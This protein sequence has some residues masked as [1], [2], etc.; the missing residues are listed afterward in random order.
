MPEAIRDFCRRTGQTVP[1]DEGAVIRCALES[2]ALR[3]RLVL[4]WLEQLVGGRIETIHIVGGGSQ[5]RQLCQ[6]T[7]DACQRAVL[8]GPVEATAIG[9]VLVQAIAAGDIGSIGEAREVGSPQF[10]AR[11]LRAAQR[12]R[13]WDA[14]FEKF[15][16]VG[17]AMNRI[18]LIATVVVL[19]QPGRH[20]RARPG[21]RAAGRRSGAVAIGIRVRR[22]HRWRRW[23]PWSCIGLAGARPARL[24]L[25]V[26]MLA[27]PA[28]RRVLPLHRGQPRPR[29]PSARGRRPGLFVATAILLLPVEAIGAAFGFWSWVNCGSPDE[30]RRI[31]R[32][33]LDEFDQ[34]FCNISRRDLAMIR[35]RHRRHRLHGHDPLPGLPEAQGGEGRGHV[36]AGP[37]AAGRRLAHDQGQL[38][39][40]RH[41]D[42]SVGHRQVRTARRRCWPIRQARHDRHLPAAGGA[43]AGGDRGAQGRQARVLRKADRAVAGRRRRGWSRR[44]RPPASN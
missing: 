33:R 21:P 31:V 38:R 3:Y 34:R 13:A 7:A 22:D 5:N 1:A 4:G 44:P 14:A 41:D 2:L 29:E 16:S 43:R 32:A 36:R 9:N 42:G 25:G 23:C 39:A 26:S 18:A 15:S 6:A 27:Q 20:R 30:R 10:S 8:A 12:G 35:R 28:V 37:H 24:L 40:G 11:A 17:E 19:V